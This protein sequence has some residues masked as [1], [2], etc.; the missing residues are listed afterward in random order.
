MRISI[1]DECGTDLLS[2]LTLDG[3][4]A[5]EGEDYVRWEGTYHKNGKWSFTE[6]GVALKEGYVI[7][8]KRSTHRSSNNHR[9]VIVVEKN[10]KMFEL[11][12]MKRIDETVEHPFNRS[13]G[14][15][16]ISPEIWRKIVE[17]TFEN[18][19]QEKLASAIKRWETIEKF[20]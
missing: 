20:K 6:G 8:N 11:F 2:V 1:R 16:P 14:D 9:W 10:K 15:F 7:I 12:I 3:T 19:N 4:K 5:I 17:A 13:L 18:L